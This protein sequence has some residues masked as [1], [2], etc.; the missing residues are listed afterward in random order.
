[1][2]ESKEEEALQWPRCG[3]CGSPDLRE[4][5]RGGFVESCLRLAGCTLYRCENCERRFAFATLGHPHRHHERVPLKTKSA[6]ELEAHVIAE[7]RRRSALRVLATLLAALGTFVTVAWLISN[8]ERRRLEQQE[9][10][11]SPQ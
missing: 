1:V 4:S 7:G 9:T 8:S 6:E 5:R 10:P 3:Y 2:N 11:P